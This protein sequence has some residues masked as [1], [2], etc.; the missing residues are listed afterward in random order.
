MFAKGSGIHG[1]G[2]FARTDIPAGTR[3]VKYSGPRL[4][5]EQGRRAAAEGNTFV[6]RVNRREAVD[7]SVKW[8]LGRHANHS[9]APNAESE[10]AGGE[11]WLRS[12]RPILKGEEITYDYGYSFRDDPA[13][14]LCGAS[15]CAG[16]I[17]AS[18]HR[19]RLEKK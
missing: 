15:Q 7:G 2:L 11:I 3:M 14:C 1:N 12:L 18:R 9:C 10:N 6:F 13:P 4:S 16:I 19:V 17:V 8:N 5:L